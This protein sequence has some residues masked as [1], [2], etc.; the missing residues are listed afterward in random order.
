MSHVT[1]KKKVHT[2]TFMFLILQ[3]ETEYLH[4]FDNRIE[5]E[6]FLMLLRPY[7]HGFKKNKRFFFFFFFYLF[8]RKYFL[9]IHILSR[10]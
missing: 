8:L 1:R 2:R 10:K 5:L 3:F 9:Y 6:R 7:A 4:F